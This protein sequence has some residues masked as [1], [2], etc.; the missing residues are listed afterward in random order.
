MKV[1][2]DLIEREGG[3]SN[4]AEDAGGETCWGITKAVARANGYDGP[5]IAMPR[6]FAEAVYKGEYI[7]KPGFH[8]VL[9]L[10]ETIGEEVIDTGVNMGQ[11][12]A[13]KFLQRSLN[14]LN[15]CEEIYPDIVV[16]GII[17]A[18][19]LRALAAYLKA[20]QDVGEVVL[21]R[22]LNCL[23]GA[24]Y[25]ELAEKRE[26]DEKNIYGWLRARIV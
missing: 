20:R 15:S 13:A 14:V 8:H 5:M 6:S 26:H 25:I 21:L 9:A 1:I 11:G 3:Y 2:D 10:S 4:R 7:I 17:G 12:T 16:D 23:Q 19:S 22:A 18:G 24:R